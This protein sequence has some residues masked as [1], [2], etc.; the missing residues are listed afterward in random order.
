M[1]RQKGYRRGKESPACRRSGQAEHPARRSRRA[2]PPVL[3]CTSAPTGRMFPAL[4]GESHRLRK[5]RS[6]G[7]PLRVAAP[8]AFPSDHSPSRLSEAIRQTDRQPGQKPG[9]GAA[10]GKAARKCFEDRRRSVQ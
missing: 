9:V 4:S 1:A 2:D 5:L 6:S 3:T 7:S 8:C 10:P